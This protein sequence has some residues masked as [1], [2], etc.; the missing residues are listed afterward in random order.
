MP[1]EDAVQP[2]RGSSDAAEPFWRAAILFRLVALLFAATVVAVNLDA[3]QRP[4]WAWAALGVMAA[5]TVYTGLR[6]ASPGGRRVRVVAADVVVTAVL[7]YSSVFLL[8]GTSLHSSFPTIT[9]VWTC[10]PVI[11]AGVLAG[12]QGG[13]LAG[14]VLSVVNMVTRGAVDA[15]MS[16]DAVLL[17]GLGFLVGLASSTARRSADR[18]RRAHQLEAATAERERLARSIH[19]GTLQVL[20]RMR[21]LGAELDG[22]AAELGRLAGEQENAL[23]VLLAASPPGAEYADG[24]ADLSAQL[25]VLATA[26]V[27]VSVPAAPVLLP[28]AVASELVA[29]AREALANTARHAGPAARSWILLEDL[30]TEVA[31]SVRDDGPGI[32]AGRLATAEA[33][34]RMGVARSMRGRVTD[35]GGTAHLETQPGSGTE[36]EIRIPRQ[37]GRAG[38]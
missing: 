2:S 16:R 38:R 33:E 22:E 15:D 17:T 13:L 27:Q 37:P 1:D 35:L 25:Q 23:R 21:R 34:G 10:G 20:A 4:R 28:A 30:D 7:Q 9:T 6:F 5:W 14:L 31:L 3:Y 19:D 32:P 36:W 29:V 24:T 8:T 11:A 12:R 26:G 18:L